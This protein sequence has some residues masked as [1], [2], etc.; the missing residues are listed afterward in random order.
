MSTQDF[1]SDEPTTSAGVNLADAIVDLLEAS[2][3]PDLFDMWFN[4]GCIEV[5]EESAGRVVRVFAKNEFS[6]RRLQQT[7]SSDIKKAVER[8]CGPQTTI[9]VEVAQP[10]SN[11]SDQTP[12]GE[13]EAPVDSTVQQAIPFA[14]SGIVETNASRSIKRAMPTL[15]AFSF[16][17]DAK[18]LRAG[19]AQLFESPGQFSPLFIH[20]PTGCGKTHLL[21]AITHGFRKKLR[22]K[23]CV[24]VSAEQFTTCLLYT[25]PSPRDLSTSRMPSSA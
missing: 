9:R 12:Q 21:E 1:S 23:R 16:A 8:V 22:L 3:G 14:A 7:F 19:V 11:V 13:A 2:I 6:V 20:G 15:E 25:S 4:R 18:L 24:Y 17:P 5:S 10:D